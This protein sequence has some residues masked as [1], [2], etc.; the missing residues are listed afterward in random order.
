MAHKT[1]SESLYKLHIMLLPKV[2]SRLSKIVS[3]YVRKEI[4]LLITFRI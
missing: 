4:R 2:F 1:F 3:L